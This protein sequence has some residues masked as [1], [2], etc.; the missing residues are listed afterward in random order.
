MQLASQAAPCSSSFNFMVC[1][2][3]QLAFRQAAKN[4]ATEIL[5]IDEMT[6]R[7]LEMNSLFNREKLKR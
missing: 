1:A 5:R 2:L 6:F 7:L 3:G 4:G